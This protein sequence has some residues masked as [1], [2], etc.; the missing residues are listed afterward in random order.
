MRSWFLLKGLQGAADTNKDSKIDLAELYSYLK[1]QVQGM[2]RREFN[3]DQAPQL[4]G[5]PD[6]LRKG[7]PLLEL[8]R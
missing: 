8:V 6:V 4:L 5:N 1:L 3:N 2:A 7:I